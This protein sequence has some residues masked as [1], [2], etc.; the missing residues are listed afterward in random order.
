MEQ[1]QANLRYLCDESRML[2]GIT[3]AY[4]TATQSESILYGRA[5]EVRLTEDGAFVPCV[6]PLLPDALYDLASLTKLFT[7]VM[8]MQLVESGR[9]SLEE[10]VGAI[11]S[12]FRNLHDV[13]VLD[14]LSFRASLRTPGRIDEAPDREEGLAR[15]FGAERVEPPRIRLYSDIN[16]MVMKYVIEQKTGMPFGN[17]LRQFI[18]SPIGLTDTY[19]HVPQHMKDRCVCYSYEHRIAGDAFRR[20]TDPLPGQPHDPKALLLSGD[21]QDLC[22]HAGLFSTRADMI[23]FAQAL[24]SGELLRPASLSAMG[25]NYTGIDYGDGTH[26]QYL[27]LLCF[28]KHPNQT[29]SEVPEW[30]TP[31]SFGVSGF[32]GN[33]LSIDPYAQH[34]VLFLGNRCHDR[35]SNIQLPEGR[36]YTDYGLAENGTGRVLWPDGRSISSSARYVYFKDERL[37]NPI[38]RR[39]QSLGWA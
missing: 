26:R 2:T 24:L 32:T 23:R 10:T 21:G 29:L 9:L 11:D 17:A 18:F 14:V 33:H 16:A 13:S 5:Q 7:C 30:M 1:L 19:A 37:N 27:G 28:A 31:G 4:G 15:L 34:F 36:S 25:R 12:R 39:M 6:R 3:A 38:A 22:G 20:R 35:V 8:A